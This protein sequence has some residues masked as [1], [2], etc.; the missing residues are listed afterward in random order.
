MAKQQCTLY[1]INYYEVKYAT[2]C[3]STFAGDN[4]LGVVRVDFFHMF[5]KGLITH[6]MNRLS[7][8][9]DERLANTHSKAAARK[10]INYS[11]N[12]RT[13]Q[14]PAVDGFVKRFVQLKTGYYAISSPW[15]YQSE[16]FLVIAPHLFTLDLLT[17]HQFMSPLE[18]RQFLRIMINLRS[19]AFRVEPLLNRTYTTDDIDS[20]HS[21]AAR[22]RKDMFELLYRV[23]FFKNHWITTMIEGILHHGVGQCDYLESMHK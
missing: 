2:H 7:D 4:F 6:V 8:L 12:A 5:S 11:I 20:L 9:L 14:F 18:A 16:A 19:L 22:L 3:P 1:S 21:V 10:F 23:D 13:T 17:Y 15:G